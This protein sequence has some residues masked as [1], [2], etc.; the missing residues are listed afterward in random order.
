M[1]RRRPD[2]ARHAMRLSAHLLCFWGAT[3][4]LSYREAQAERAVHAQQGSARRARRRGG[5]RTRALARLLGLGLAL[6]LG[7][8]GLLGRLRLARLLGRL[9]LLLPPADR[10][11]PR[12]SARARCGRTARGPQAGRRRSQ[13]RQVEGEQGLRKQSV[14]SNAVAV[15]QP[16]RQA[17]AACL[18]GT[19]RSQSAAVRQPCRQACAACLAGTARS[20]SA[21]V[22]QPCRQAC[23]AGPAGAA[24]A[25]FRLS[26]WSCR[27][28]FSL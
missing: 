21:A 7:R 17:C 22:R 20:Q 27:S 5:P 28:V 25:C 19:A 26:C 10:L 15:R 2:A 12:L 8:L 4:T 11:R 3:Q 23:A 6:G 1:T 9:A 16:C 24:R 13:A 14:C 18:A